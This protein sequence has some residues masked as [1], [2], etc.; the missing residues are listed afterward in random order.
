[1][2][3]VLWLTLVVAAAPPRVALMT[4]SRVGVAEKEEAQL[5][6]KLTAALKEAG[7]SVLEVSLPCQGDS[8]CLQ[9]QGRALDVEAIV[10]IT[11]AGGPRQIAIDVETVLVR[12]AASLDQRSIN[13]K[14]KTAVEG[15]GPQLHEC[16]ASIA[17]KVLAERPPDAPTKVSLIPVA[18]LPP[19][20][21][22]LAPP[23]VNRAPEVVTGA[24]A[25]ALG[26][27]AAVL[28]GLAADQQA[29]LAVP[30]T[31]TLAQAVARRDEANTLYT[32]AAVSG[33]VAG[34]LA[35]TTLTLML[36]R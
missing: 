32:A 31:H 22:V 21:V 6:A 11:L 20:V 33:G 30:Y 10:T 5:N 16:A 8:K 23:P 19:R 24:T 13:W 36:V 14:N 27:V 26:L 35:V 29:R 3:G 12:S 4:A 15:L 2:M 9:E 34:A 7:L 18:V 28:T 25:V 1:M 17:Q